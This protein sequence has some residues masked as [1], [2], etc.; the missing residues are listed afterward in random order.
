[1]VTLEQLHAR[2]PHELRP[3]SVGP[4][5]RQIVRGVHI[6]ELV[7]P[8]PY[9]EGGELLLTTGIPFAHG[10]VSRANGNTAFLRADRKPGGQRTFRIVPGEPL[11]TS[12][13]ED[14]FRRD[15]GD[16]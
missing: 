5:G 3:V 12:F 4:V 2:V 7:D 11:K 8:T 16:G 15:F 9:L 13:G 14:L 10:F 1:M 6:S